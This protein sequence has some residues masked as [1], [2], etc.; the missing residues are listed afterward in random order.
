V[1]AL[2]EVR[3]LVIEYG[4]G[5]Y[6]VR[7][8]DGLDLTADAGE[9]V[10]LLGP[11]GCGKTSLLS[12]LGGILRPTSGT[13]TVDGRSVGDLSG[14][15]LTR[16]RQRQVGFVFQAFNLIPSLTARENVAMPLMLAGAAKR[17]AMAR[18][19]ELMERVGLVEQADRR[20]SKLSGGQQQRVAVARGLAADPPLLL[21]DEPTAN[22]DYVHAEGII[23]LLRSLRADGRLI[24]IST[25]DDRLVPIADRVVK[26]V[27]DAPRQDS[28]ARVVELAAGDVVF[29]QGSRAEFVYVV[30]SGVVE[31]TRQRADGTREELANVGP[32]K[33]FGELGP[34]LG[35][36]RSATATALTP[37]RLRAIGITEFRSEFVDATA[38]AGADRDPGH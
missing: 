33:Y 14:A 28:A 37:V 32:G 27:P 30:E 17:R 21:A 15:A 10:V 35:F 11:S 7:P 23:Q 38:G 22:L 8:I 12:A 20:P 2:L 25:H 36:P 5:D 19:D 6:P 29:E 9:L 26:L 4:G 13:V 3:E 31:I 1:S 24:V 18:A 16:Y 34:L